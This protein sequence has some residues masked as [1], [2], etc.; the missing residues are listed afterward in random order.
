[1]IS[2]LCLCINFQVYIHNSF[3]IVVVGGGCVCVCVCVNSFVSLDLASDS[4]QSIMFQIIIIVLQI[5]CGQYRPR[6]KTGITVDLNLAACQYNNDRASACSPCLVWSH[7]RDQASFH[8]VKF[9]S[10]PTY[11]TPLKT[12]QQYYVTRNNRQTLLENRTKE[13]ELGIQNNC[14][15]LFFGRVWV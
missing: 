3:F 9:S 13:P 6:Q 5:K 10:I 2:L 1:M 4:Q 8:S 15:L 12:V 11:V 7:V 14:V